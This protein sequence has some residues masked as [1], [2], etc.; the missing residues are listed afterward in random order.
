MLIV[1]STCSTVNIAS[2]QDLR[3]NRGGMPYDQGLRGAEGIMKLSK[4]YL[5]AN[6]TDSMSWTERRPLQR[7]VIYDCWTI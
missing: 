1:R 7:E 4:T 2:G 3:S 6:M 5:A